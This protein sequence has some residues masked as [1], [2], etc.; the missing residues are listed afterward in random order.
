M[1]ADRVSWVSGIVEL[2]FWCP[3]KIATIKVIRKVTL[4]DPGVANDDWGESL[5]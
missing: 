1:H 5:T 4:E 3:K 2:K